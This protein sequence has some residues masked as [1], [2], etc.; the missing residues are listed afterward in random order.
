M[1]IHLI[2]VRCPALWVRTGLASLLLASGLSVLAMPPKN[3]VLVRLDPPIP[4]AQKMAMEESIERFKTRFARKKQ[5][6]P[7]LN[8]AQLV[9]LVKSVAAEWNPIAVQ[10]KELGTRFYAAFEAAMEKQQKL[11]ALPPGRSK[12]ELQTVNGTEMVLAVNQSYWIGSLTA[13]LNALNA[14]VVAFFK[15]TGTS[16]YSNQAP[17]AAA[18]PEPPAFTRAHDKVLRAAILEGLKQ[19]TRTEQ[20]LEQAE[21]GASLAQ[22][23]LDREEADYQAMLAARSAKVAHLEELD[24]RRAQARAARAAAEAAHL[25]EQAASGAQSSA[26]PSRTALEAEREEAYQTARAHALAMEEADQDDRLAYQTDLRALNASIEVENH[27][28][29]AAAARPAAAAAEVKPAPSRY[30][31]IWDL[32]AKKKLQKLADPAT[33]TAIKA[34]VEKLRNEGPELVGTPHST[35]LALDR[36]LFELRPNSG[37]SNQRI[38]YAETDTGYLILSIVTKVGTGKLDVNDLQ[39]ALERLVVRQ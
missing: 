14:E 29:A 4:E 18:G 26:E 15:E 17:A 6:M 27:R 11:A 19:Q 39:T 36:R 9:D 34:V 23:T 32:K 21:R 25:R 22:S 33:R 8:P 13:R 3:S 37:Q 35:H 24:A 38:L 28:R 16:T 7:A 30:K 12:K 5:L 31:V 1:S 20:I 2:A 10:G